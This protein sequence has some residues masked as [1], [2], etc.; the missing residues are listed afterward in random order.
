[1]Y[2]KYHSTIIIVL[3]LFFILYVPFLTIKDKCFYS[4]AIS[5]FAADSFYYLNVADKFSKTNTFTYDGT[6]TTNGF[7][8]L[9]QYFLA[10]SFKY[11]N[12][13]LSELH[14]F[15]SPLPEAH[16]HGNTLKTH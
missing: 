10:N 14:I 7:H 6:H 1:M 12:R 11:I 15:P 13:I 9:W 16:R 5:F 4:G 8:P 3:T 2:K